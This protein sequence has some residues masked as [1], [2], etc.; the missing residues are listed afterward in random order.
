M[1]GIKSKGRNIKMNHAKSQI[2]VFKRLA[3]DQNLRKHRAFIWDNSEDLITTPNIYQS[4]NKLKKSKSVRLFCL[5][6]NSL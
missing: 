4:F 5:S 6:L 3:N 1:I 2:N